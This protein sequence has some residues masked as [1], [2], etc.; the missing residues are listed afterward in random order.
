MFQQLQMLPQ[1]PRAPEDPLQFRGPPHSLRALQSS[2]QSQRSPTAT[3]ATTDPDS[4]QLQRLSTAPEA[5]PV[6]EP[7]PTHSSEAHHSPRI[8]LQPQRHPTVLEAPH[9]SRGPPTAPHSSYWTAA[10]RAAAEYHYQERLPV[11][12]VLAAVRGACGCC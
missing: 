9:S 12:D 5:P 10:T 8:T 1:V 2:P 4:P 3:E 7:P 6:P 11:I